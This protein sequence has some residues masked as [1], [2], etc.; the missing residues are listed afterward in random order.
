[1]ASK[2]RKTLKTYFQTGKIPTQEQYADLIDS[3]LNIVDTDSQIIASDLTINGDVDINGTLEANSI[4][5]GLGDFEIGQNLRTTDNVTFSNIFASGSN[6]HIT[7]SGNIS[8]SGTIVASNFSG[9]TSG[10]NTGDQSLV[11]LA[12]T[13]SDVVFANITS[14]GNIS[15]SGDV[16]ANNLTA[17]STG[18]FEELHAN[19]ISASGV[20]SSPL[21]IGP[22][23]NT[24]GGSQLTLKASSFGFASRFTFNVAAKN[25][26]TI[27]TTVSQQSQGGRGNFYITSGSTTTPT[28][29]SKIILFASASNS[30][31]GIATKEPTEKLTVHGNLL[32]SGSGLG[33]GSFSSLKIDGSSVDF[34]NLPTSD[35]NIAGRLY[36]DSGT[37]KISL[38]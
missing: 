13:S 22:K 36:N 34:T 32:V 33:T 11:H 38:G 24:F 4:N 18:S 19:N 12:V 26:Y 37:V 8:S 23:T 31:V 16:I 7:A 15:A 1:M 5:T 2:K 29:D 30:N 10:T 25:S 3:K 6:G 20:F 28:I 21:T 35:P 17:T 14:S 9:A 27:G